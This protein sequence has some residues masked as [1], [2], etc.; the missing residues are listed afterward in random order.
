M[1]NDTDEDTVIY[2][3]MDQMKSDG[4]IETFPRWK[5]HTE[6]MSLHEKAQEELQA[7]LE[8][9]TKRFGGKS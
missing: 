8:E 2:Y 7:L 4:S 3:V 5:A 6:F 9:A 1:P